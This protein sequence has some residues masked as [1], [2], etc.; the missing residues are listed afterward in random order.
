[1]RWGGGIAA[2]ESGIHP[3]FRNPQAH[4]LSRASAC[5]A[6]PQHPSG[7]CAACR[8]HRPPAPLRYLCRVRGPPAPGTP[9]V[10]RPPVAWRRAP[11][12][13]R[14][15]RRSGRTGSPS[16]LCRMGRQC[17]GSPRLGRTQSPPRHT[18]PPHPC[19]SLRRTPN[20]YHHHA[21]VLS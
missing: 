16:G 15:C 18:L 4:L 13:A 5:R 21:L 12:P 7:I 3:V 20:L 8:A 6:G 19:A 10:S 2:G 9:A 17:E 14:A 1:M 11:E